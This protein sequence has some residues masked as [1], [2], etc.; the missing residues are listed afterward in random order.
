[1]NELPD[2]VRRI[3]R[4]AAFAKGSF[5]FQAEEPAGAFF[6]ILSGEI[7]V[8]KMDDQ[9]RELEVTRLGGG[10]FVGEA[11]A[12]VHGRYPFFAQAAKESRTLVF[13]AE[14]AEKAIANG[15]DAARFFVRLLARKCVQLSSRVESLGMKTVRQRLSEY[16]LAGCGG[17][18]PCAIA[19]P[20]KKGEL[21]KAL[22][23]VGETLSRTLRQM[24]D[25]GLIRVEGKTIRVIDGPGLRRESG[26]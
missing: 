2:L 11:F 6:Y 19:L 10:E 4:E 12:L 15:S 22:G 26:S 3:G 23:T 20:M 13:G 1:M 21:A 9:G 5:L 14:A 16:L 17:G 8:F 24:Q 18:G 25:E 7:R